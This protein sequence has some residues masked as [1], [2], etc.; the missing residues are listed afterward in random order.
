MYHQQ[1]IE[2]NWTKK[3]TV[4]PDMKKNNS[5][6]LL[7]ILKNFI[8]F[9]LKR[10]KKTLSLNQEFDIIK[11]EQEFFNQKVVC[12]FK[13][14]FCLRDAVIDNYANQRNYFHKH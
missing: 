8:K 9:K 4:K 1:E 14:L 3:S 6:F 2:I 10:Q 5:V 7:V 13:L 11:V 12:I